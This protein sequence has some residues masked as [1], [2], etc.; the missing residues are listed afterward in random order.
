MFYVY[1]FP[2][3][4]MPG[5]DVHTHFYCLNDASFFLSF[6]PVCVYVLIVSIFARA[7]FI[8]GLWAVEEARK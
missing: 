6:V 4:I 1:I 8:I 5:R 2:R 3:R 7:Y